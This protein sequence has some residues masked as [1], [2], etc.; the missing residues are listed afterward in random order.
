MQLHMENIREDMASERRLSGHHPSEG[1]ATA[2]DYE[3]SYGS[4]DD[5]SIRSAPRC[6]PHESQAASAKHDKKE[7]LATKQVSER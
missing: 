3:N 5:R 2:R 6:H 4:H 7:R 1:Q